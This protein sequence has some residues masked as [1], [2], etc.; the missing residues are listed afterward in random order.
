MHIARTSHAQCMHLQGA[1]GRKVNEARCR[2][3]GKAAPFIR[4]AYQNSCRVGRNRISLMSTSSG[5]AMAKATARA[6]E[7]AGIATSA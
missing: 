5:W 4:I 7:S 3:G 6:K 2:G 1:P